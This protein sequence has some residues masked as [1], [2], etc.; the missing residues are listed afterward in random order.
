MYAKHW[1]SHER[2]YMRTASGAE[3]SILGNLSY[4]EWVMEI[5]FMYM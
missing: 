5:I 4:T 2:F 1:V 3:Y